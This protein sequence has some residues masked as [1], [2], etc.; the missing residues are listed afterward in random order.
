MRHHHTLVL[1]WAWNQLVLFFVCHAWFETLAPLKM[2]WF[3]YSS[4][5]ILKQTISAHRM[6]FV[7]YR[8]VSPWIVGYIGTIDN[9]RCSS[10]IRWMFNVFEAQASNKRLQNWPAS[11]KNHTR[12]VA[13]SK[14]SF[15]RTVINSNS[16]KW[17]L[18]EKISFRTVYSKFSEMMFW[19]CGFIFHVI[20]WV[21]KENRYWISPYF[22]EFSR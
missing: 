7:D 2:G 11:R 22:Q 20:T 17:V 8:T 9:E 19:M 1:D 14:I 13:W 15:R 12:A 5:V 4:V 18:P 10:T 3:W 16:P 21:I 6:M